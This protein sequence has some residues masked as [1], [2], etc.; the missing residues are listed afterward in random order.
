M[1]C[2][3]AVVVFFSY[4]VSCCAMLLHDAQDPVVGSSSQGL[5]TLRGLGERMAAAVANRHQGGDAGL[6]AA[7]TSAATLQAALTDVVS[8]TSLDGLL[9]LK[10]QC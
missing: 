8:Y 2:P 1:C 6:G 3:E 4:V 10:G 7:A 9:D 5:C